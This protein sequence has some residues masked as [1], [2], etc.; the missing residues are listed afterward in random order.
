VVGA[1][2]SPD[3]YALCA[4]ARLHGPFASAVCELRA[5]RPDPLLLVGVSSEC[6]GLPDHASQAGEGVMT[7]AQTVAQ[8]LRRLAKK[9][10]SRS[11]IA[12]VLKAATLLE[13]QE[14]GK[15]LRAASQPAVPATVAP[16]NDAE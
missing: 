11:Q 15:R 3:L 4:D 10:E 12:V 9:L 14:R 8:Q 6:D 1:R 2:R 7:E 13:T 5:H 16:S